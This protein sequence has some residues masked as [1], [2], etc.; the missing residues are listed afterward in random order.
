MGEESRRFYL[1][2]HEW[3]KFC[4]IDALI[5]GSNS[6]GFTPCLRYIC[7]GVN[8]RGHFGTKLFFFE[9]YFYRS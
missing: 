7:I 3:Q 9:L 6:R 4:L 1:H 5:G 2:K 8:K